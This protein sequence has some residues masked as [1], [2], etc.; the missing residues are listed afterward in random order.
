M[1]DERIVELLYE[2]NEKGLT[3]TKNKYEQKCRY[4]EN[5]QR[6]LFLVDH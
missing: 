2:H 3:E 6:R 5:D 4:E 1:E